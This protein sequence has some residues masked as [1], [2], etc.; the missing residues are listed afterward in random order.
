MYVYKFTFTMPPPIP[1]S[2][3]PEFFPYLQFFLFFISFF[4]FCVY[5]T[6]YCICCIVYLMNVVFIL[7]FAFLNRFF[8]FI[9]VAHEH[10][11]LFVFFFEFPSCISITCYCYFKIVE[12]FI[13]ILFGSRLLFLVFCYFC[14]FVADAYVSLSSLCFPL[15][16]LVIHKSPSSIRRS[17]CPILHSSFSHSTLLSFLIY[18]LFL[19]F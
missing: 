4:K 1:V 11:C 9:V 15:P 18:F 14:C 5:C 7:F 10:R 2:F 13:Q 3:A 8:D 12:L 17:F 6:C 19:L 16:F